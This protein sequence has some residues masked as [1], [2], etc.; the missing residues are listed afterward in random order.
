MRRDLGNEFDYT[1]Y[2]AIVWTLEIDCTTNIVSISMGPVAV[3]FRR[4]VVTAA[5]LPDS[6]LF[7]SPEHALNGYNRVT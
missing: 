2:E 3:F 5:E 4:F 6:V 7:A 1:C